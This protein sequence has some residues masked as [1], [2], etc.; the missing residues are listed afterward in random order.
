MC[1]VFIN[2]LL[3]GNEKI[4]PRTYSLEGSYVVLTNPIN[5]I[6]I[7]RPRP[8]LLLI[9]VPGTDG[10]AEGIEV[11]CGPFLLFGTWCPALTVLD[12]FAPKIQSA[13]IVK[14]RPFT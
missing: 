12:W 14:A 4:P 6:L 2:N 11:F 8:P 13:T 3:S 1:S 9:D 5:P 7:G 10:R